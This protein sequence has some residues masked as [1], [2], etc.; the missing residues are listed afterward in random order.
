[1]S[2]DTVTV[3]TYGNW[4]RAV[5]FGIGHWSAAQSVT[6]LAA[7]LAPVVLLYVSPAAAAVCALASVLVCVVALV[8]I[9]GAPVGTVLAR[10]A[11]FRGARRRGWTQLSGGVLTEHPRREDLP[12]LM[13][14]Q[15]PLEGD[16]G[17]GGRQALLWHRRTGWITAVLRVAPVGLE[18]ADQAQADQWVATWGQWLA[19][20]GHQPLVRHVTITV[21]T[22]PSGGATLADFVT[23]RRSPDSPE[24][25]RAIM[26]E[27]VAATPEV[28]ADTSTW[29]SV[30]FDPA[31]ADPKPKDLL[32]ATAEVTRWLPGLERSLAACGVSVLG[33]ASLAWLTGTLRA[34]YDPASRA[35]LA[36]ASERDQVLAWSEAGPVRTREDWDAWRHDS[37]ISVAWGLREAPRSA[38]T[39]RVLAPL[40]SPGPY[41]R[42]VTLLYR[43]R[44]AAE[45]A[46]AVEAEIGNLAT[47]AEWARRTRRDETQ[48]ERDDAARAQQAARE[49]SQGAGVG[50]FTVYVSTTVPTAAEDL[51]PAATSDVELRAGQAKTRLRRLHGAHAAGMAAALGLGVDPAGLEARGVR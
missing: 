29:L 49:E 23:S 30:T 7:V 12:G 13:A 51:L 21:D 22:A 42:R 3:R 38:V 9:G 15:V 1:M 37:G 20:L 33:R 43:P 34:A 27:V 11:T 16:D 32:G 5:G 36:H 24:A 19:D 8:P 10:R 26:D 48:R 2:S 6:V 18:L 14:P 47:R 17:R 40:L 39:E 35:D 50:A 44:P 28:T 45:A 46:R 25:A 31:Y 4:R 41:P